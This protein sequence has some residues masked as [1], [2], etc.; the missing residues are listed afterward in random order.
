MSLFVTINYEF[1]NLARI[2]ECYFILSGF[3]ARKIF[4]PLEVKCAN[5]ANLNPVIFIYP[6]I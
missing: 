2:H 5:K 4:T 6:F 1:T 3:K